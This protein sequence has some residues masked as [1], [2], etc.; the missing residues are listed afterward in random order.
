MGADHEA[1]LLAEIRARP[2]DDGPRLVFADALSDRGD[3]WGELIVA[4]CELA[5]LAR[6]GAI[7]AERRRG[8]DERCRELRQQRW[9]ERSWKF[10][11][12]LDRGF[13]ASVEAASNEMATVEG[14]EF[15][16]LR[17]VRLWGD[18]TALTAL[19]DWPSL[20]QL[21]RLVFR[22]NVERHYRSL[23]LSAEAQAIRAA[24]FAR[25]GE[26]VR[27]S[28]IELLNIEY[29]DDE[30]RRFARTPLRATLR[31]FAVE[32]HPR[33]AIEL[34]WPALEA[35]ALVDLRLTGEDLAHALRRPALDSLAALDVSSN[36]FGDL[37]LQAIL[38]RELPNLR[39]LR[40]RRVFLHPDA[41][42]A[43]ARSSLTGRLEAL[44]IGDDHADPTSRALCMLVEAG[45]QL[46]D[47]E[48]DHPSLSSEDTADIV[49]RLRGP[50]RKLRLRGGGDGLAMVRALLRNP[51][52]RGLRRLD[53]AGQP[54]GHAAVALLA[55]AE[56][57]ALEWL[58]LSN[59]RLDQ[60]S[61]HALAYSPTLPS[62]IAL[63]LYGNARG[64][65]SITGPLL[66]RFHDVRY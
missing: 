61:A 10:D 12:A 9:R 57:P 51:A 38:D 1:A 45:R 58:D 55:R 34:D 20:G 40:M 4:G 30:L 49:R 39:T 31:R 29:Q 48:I 52:S 2:D 14:Y 23:F 59:C 25:I 33:A 22:G 15:A 46:V 56:L 50:L 19:A 43:L 17:E 41:V 16:V 44:S 28:S 35:L 5:R 21:D 42:R 60:E 13:C 32:R 47:L 37:G 18:S 11:A 64:P 53:L 8:L 66:A 54:I 6:N 63:R 62:R 36:V 26:R 7:D 65:E 3:P 24:A 27:P